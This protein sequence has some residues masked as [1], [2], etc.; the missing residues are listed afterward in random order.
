[1][2]PRFDVTSGYAPSGA[3]KI[4]FESA[5]TG[6]NLIFAHAGISDSRMWDPQFESFAERFRVVRYDH[7]GFGKSKL[8]DEPYALADDLL[9]VLRHLSVAKT[10]LVGCSMGGT[11]AIDFALEHPEMVAALVLVG[12]GVSGLNDPKELSA[13]AI[14]HWIELIGLVQKGDVERAREMDAKYWIDGPS[15]DAAK[16]APVYR[17]RARELHRENFSIERFTR[18]EEPLK[19]PAIGRLCEITA[20]TL[21]VI[22]DSDSEDLLRLAERFAVEIPNARLA[23]ISN[24]A[25]LPSLEHPDEF[26]RIVSDFLD[27][28]S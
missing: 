26:N 20:P 7:R 19:P 10:A 11:A 16:V 5:G 28:G 1:M 6:R 23:T 15:R 17:D 8:T 12:S 9:N 3:A 18:Q 2:A 24:A 25:H 22:G 21:V 4:Y 14:K 27:S 13:E